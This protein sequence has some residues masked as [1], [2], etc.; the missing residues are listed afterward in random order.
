MSISSNTFG[1]K[2]AMRM[3]QHDLYGYD[4]VENSNENETETI[5]QKG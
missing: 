4:K 3:T 1:F 2:Q 5:S